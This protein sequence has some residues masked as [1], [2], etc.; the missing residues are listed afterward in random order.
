MVDETDENRLHALAPRGVRAFVS[1]LASLLLAFGAAAQDVPEP[2]PRPPEFGSARRSSGADAVIPLP[3]ERPKENVETP[4]A[5]PDAKAAPASPAP[6]PET[7]NRSIARQ[8]IKP[9]DMEPE[10]ECKAALGREGLKA[11]PLPTIAQGQCGAPRPLS[12]TAL[13]TGVGV[14]PKSTLNCGIAMVLADWLREDVQPEAETSLKARVST[15]ELATSYDCRTT[16]RV[17]GAKMS[18]HA[19]ANAVDVAAFRLSDGRRVTIAPKKNGASDSGEEA[20]LTAI[21]ASACRRFTTVLGPGSDAEHGDHL[22]VD[23]R[24]RNGAYRICQ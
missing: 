23:L 8:P 19:Y 14:T 17:P 20:F 7:P 21:R 12:V 1:V 9:P 16:N 18:E 15:L 5:S 10:E 13:A 2:P 6:V 11:E 4:P 24:A 22:H 3:P